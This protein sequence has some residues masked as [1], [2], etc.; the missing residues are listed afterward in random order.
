MIL[1]AECKECGTQYSKSS[2]A[3]NLE[4][5]CPKCGSQAV[6]LLEMGNHRPPDWYRQKET[7]FQ[8]FKR[9]VGV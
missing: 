2:K 6:S 7:F 5:V 9:F 1:Y 4:S 3:G 8:K